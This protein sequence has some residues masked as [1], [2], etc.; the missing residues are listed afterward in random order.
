MNFK[1]SAAALLP[2]LKQDRHWLH[3]HPELSFQEYGTTAYIAEQLRAVGIEVVLFP[4][5]TGCIGVI[6]GEASGKTVLLR[7]DIDAL[8]IK[9]NSGVAYASENDGVMHACGHDAHTAMLLGAA[10]LLQDARGELRGSVKLLFQAAEEGFTG[11]YYYVDKGYLDDVDFAYGQHV[12][13]ELPVGQI[14]VSDGYRMASCDNFAITVEGISAHGSA[15]HLGR[16]AIVAASSILLALQTLVS[17][18]NDPANPLVVSVCRMRAG[19][20]FNII[21]DKAVLEGT[22][23]TY[24]L[25]IRDSI[26]PEMRRLTASIAAAHG[27]T[28][29]L[30]YHRYDEP[31]I[32]G[33]SKVNELARNSVR[34]LLG[35]S[36]V[37]SLPPTLASEDFGYIMQAKPAAFGFVGCGIDGAEVQK[38]HSDK[39]VMPDEAMIWGA[40]QYAQFAYDYLLCTAKEDER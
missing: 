4:D 26:E 7:A 17:R 29:Q 1:E 13:P 20:E 38:L 16:D 25:A 11:S 31:I 19:T 5:Y 32:N 28:A 8:P 24:N 15:P 39:F 21:T 9:E 33:Q 14:D 23:R 36:G 35:D 34:K 37:G 22:V 12:W 2:R 18:F 40:A 27:C 3:R 30:D 6:K 10:R